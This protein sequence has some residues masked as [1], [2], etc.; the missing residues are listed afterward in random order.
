MRDLHE[1]TAYLL[2]GVTGVAGAWCLLADRFERLRGRALWVIVIAGQLLALAQAAFGAL[3]ANQDGVV[4]DDMHALYG[5]SGVIAVG[6]L[7]SYRNSPFMRGKELLLY[8]IG[9][10]FVMGLGIR[11]L[12]LG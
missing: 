12:F 3:L 7:Y 4:L 8:G 1:T 5:F 2:I 11:N 9:S 6:I 10:W